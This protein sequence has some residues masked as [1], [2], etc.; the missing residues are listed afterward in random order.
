[1]PKLVIAKILGV[2]MTAQLPHLK[3]M[4][5]RPHN[6]LYN[7][8][9]GSSRFSATPEVTKLQIPFVSI[10]V[11]SWLNAFARGCGLG[12][13]HFAPWRQSTILAIANFGNYGNLIVLLSLTLIIA[14]GSP[15]APLPPSLNIPKPVHDL[16]AAR[17]GDAVMLSWASPQQTTDGA[18]VGKGGKIIVRRAI[19]NQPAEVIREL[20]LPPALKSDQGQTANFQESLAAM[21]ASGAG[22]FAGYTVEVTNSLGRSAGISNRVTVPLVVTPPAPAGV[23]AKVVPEG[24]SITWIRSKPQE[25]PSQLTAQYAWRLK[26]RLKEAEAKSGASKPVVVAQLESGNQD[27]AFVDK[28]IEWEKQYEYWVTPVTLWQA[29]GGEKGEVEGDDSS[30]VTVTARDIFPPAAPAGVQAVFS[31]SSQN[32]FIDLTWSPNT[33]A[34]LAG[35]NIYRHT[36]G[37]QPQ[38]INTALIKSP[39]FRDTGVG[40]GTKYFYTISAVDLR[41]NESKQS[42]ETSE[43]VP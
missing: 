25:R 3:T 8:P 21:I 23:L 16:Q 1:M 41:A 37:S 26:R 39:S 14:C 42:E 13:G 20:P 19:E 9:L 4:N 24:V 6:P 7:H 17:K 5:R 31:G 43:T 18:L 28:S 27:G 12:C 2:G 30:I 10:R 33:E 40:P 22:D 35:Y 11:N 34:D 36:E 15:G 32:L 38:K 29:A